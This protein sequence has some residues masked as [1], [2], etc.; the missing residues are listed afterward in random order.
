MRILRKKL[1][2]SLCL[3]VFILQGVLPFVQGTWPVQNVAGASVG[4]AVYGDGPG[5]VADGVYGPPENSAGAGAAGDVYAAPSPLP[6]AETLLQTVA[7]VVYDVYANVLAIEGDA[8]VKLVRA[9]E[10][11]TKVYPNVKF[12]ARSEDQALADPGLEGLLR[13]ADLIYLNRAGPALADKIKSL[14]GFPAGKK[15]VVFNSPAWLARMSNI[16]SFDFQGAEQAV[17]EINEAGDL[18]TVN[19]LV[20]A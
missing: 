12:V 18:K 17:A 15:V 14:G 7:S 9:A 6:P 5:S 11:I 2:V 3:I 10:E 20:Y 13:T 8:P 4:E 19:G 16:G 1:T